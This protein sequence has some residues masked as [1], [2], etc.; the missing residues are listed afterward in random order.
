MAELKIYFGDDSEY[1][2]ITSLDRGTRRDVLVQIDNNL[3]HPIFYHLFTLTQEYNEA[4][5]Q[6]NFYEIDNSIILVEKTSKNKII[7]AVLSL[8]KIRYFEKA[9][10]ISLE[11]EFKGSFDLFP[12]SKNLSGWVKI[13]ETVI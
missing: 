2:E 1:S 12:E 5:E 10:P 7:E 6:G 9:K 8:Y 4:I 13:Y 3:Y 11:E